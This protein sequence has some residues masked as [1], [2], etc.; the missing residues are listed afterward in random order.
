MVKYKMTGGRE[1]E[2]YKKMS[3]PMRTIVALVFLCLPH[4]NG[5]DKFND[6]ITEPVSFFRNYFNVKMP[7]R[8][9]YES[10]EEYAK[11]I[12]T[13]DT[14]KFYYFPSHFETHYEFEDR[15]L[16]IDLHDFNYPHV[17]TEFAS[18]GIELASGTTNL[19]KYVGTNAFGVKKE[20]TKL[21]IHTYNV[22]DIRLNTTIEDMLVESGH[23]YADGDQENYV[24]IDTTLDPKR[25]KSFAQ[26]LA[27]AFKMRLCGHDDGVQ[28][29]FDNTSEP[30]VDNPW[31]I[32]T[33][34]HDVH[35]F[36][37][38][39]ILYDKVS[40]KIYLKLSNQKPQ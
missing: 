17:H 37:D 15:L 23:Y 8:G 14:S 18:A 35:G 36:L 5:Q 10:P 25:A 40:K 26:N 24:R 38:E 9:E 32:Y 28:F 2:M 11:R 22:T 3:A 39:I 34:V 19:G 4:A 29:Q 27:V 13:F 12:P 30:T 31:K 6:K 20:I 16:H 1:I 33:V 21:S 7:K